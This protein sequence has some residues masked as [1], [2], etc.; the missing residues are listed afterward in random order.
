MIRGRAAST[1]VKRRENHEIRE[2]GEREK[3]E[4]RS[5]DSR[6]PFRF[7]RVSIPR[8][9]PERTSYENR[10][11]NPVRDDP[12]CAGRWPPWSTRA[13]LAAMARAQSRRQSGRLHRAE[14]LA[15]G[16]DPKMENHRR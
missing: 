15:Q 11:S 5:C 14:N 9:D 6:K 16:I 12:L 1:S 10:E 8:P 7:W 4:T 3:L 13:G 2:T